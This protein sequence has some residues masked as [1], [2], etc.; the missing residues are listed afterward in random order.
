MGQLLLPWPW[1][2]INL[3]SENSCENG[4]NQDSEDSS[5]IEYKSADIINIIK[6]ILVDE[7]STQVEP[8]DT[9]SQPSDILIFIDPSSQKCT[10][11][12]YNETFIKDITKEVFLFHIKYKT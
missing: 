5:F 4:F 2:E 12:T 1:E 6:P 9:K 10:E 8:F 7:K 3:V 11:T